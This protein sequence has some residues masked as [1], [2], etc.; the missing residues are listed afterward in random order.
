MTA[1]VASRVGEVWTWPNICVHVVE[2]ASQVHRNAQL[3]ISA[4]TDHEVQRDLINRFGNACT[5]GGGGQDH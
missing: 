1:P 5:A 4:A 2:K 3:H